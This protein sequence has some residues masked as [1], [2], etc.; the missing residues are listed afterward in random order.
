MR[1]KS[2]TW[3]NAVLKVLSLLLIFA[4][5][6]CDDD[7]CPTQE[8]STTTCA[9][10]DAA[11]V[12][13][14]GNY[15]SNNSTLTHYD[16]ETNVATQ[17]Y[18]EQRIGRLLGDTGND[19]IL[20]DNILYIVVNNSNKLEVVDTDTWTSLAKIT[21]EKDESGSSPREI[22]EYNGKLFISNFNG[23]VAVVD[24]ANSYGNEIEWIQVGTQPNGITVLDGKIYVAN[25]NYDNGYNPG[26]ISVIDPTTLT[27][28]Q[29]LSDI[30]VN[31]SSIATDDYGD[32]Y[33]ISKGNYSDASANLYV[34]NP[35]TGAIT[36]TFDITAQSI[37]I[38]GD[39]GYVSVGGYDA[40]WNYVA[41]IYKIDVEADT[42]M[43][44]DFIESSNFQT[45]YGLNVDPNT[46]DIYCLDALDYSV[47]GTVTV[48]DEDGQQTTSFKS[49]VNPCKVLFLED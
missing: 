41:S 39:V 31:I 44:E 15:E 14:E 21:L 48:F 36:K 46:G 33:V 38:H 22:V 1:E 8:C 32:L 16:M 47:S 23:Y 12:L 34:V 20:V 19:M 10:A 26:S 49:G 13:S 4:F 45:L 11:L 27:V 18:F 17:N 24:T 6:G 28:T 35:T 37:A 2:I 40:N 5:A 3:K 9:G 25:S 42:V 29:T 30:G 7:D 43:T